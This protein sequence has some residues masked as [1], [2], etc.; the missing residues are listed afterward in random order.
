MGAN[1]L[2]R[3][4]SELR[5][6][7]SQQRRRLRNARRTS[8][9]DRRRLFV[10]MLEDRRLLVASLSINDPS[11]LEG[12]SGNVNLNFTVTRGGDDML[13]NVTVA[14]NTSDTRP[15]AG[16]ATAGSDYTA[17]SGTVT[18]PSGATT[19]TVPVMGGTTIEPNEQ[20]FVNLTGI[21]NV[22]G[23]A[24]TLAAKTDFTTGTTPRSVAI[25]D[26]NGDG[27]PD[28]A[29]ANYKESSSPAVT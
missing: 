5:N 25:G 23:P 14:Y 8:R 21:T 10:E 11:V 24:A 17:C 26:L 27:K 20:L 18:I 6:F 7:G 15:A 1:W 9:S 2:H 3:T 19:I 13:S 12:N 4:L 28:L 16:A 29:I 22:T